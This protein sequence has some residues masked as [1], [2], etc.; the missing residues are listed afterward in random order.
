MAGVT[1]IIHSAGWLAGWLKGGLTVSGEN[2]IPDVEV[3]NMVPELCAGAQAGDAEIGLDALAEVQ[4]GGHFFAAAQTMGRY[5]TEFNEP[6]VHDYAN[7]GAL[8]E[9]GAKD[10]STRALMIW[11]NII[12]APQSPATDETRHGAL[13]DDITLRTT[14]GGAFPEG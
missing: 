3:L 11:Q 4:P 13:K 7:F 5:Q 12:N 6:I 14:R 1:V 10:A 2:L 9:R 8:T